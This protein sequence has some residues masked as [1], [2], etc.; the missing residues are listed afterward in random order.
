MSPPVTQ[1]FGMDDHPVRVG[2]FEREYE[3]DEVNVC[4]STCDYWDGIRFRYDGPN[5]GPCVIQRRWR[6]LAYQPD[7]TERGKS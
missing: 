7:T 3:E 6:G 4:E 2:L 5:G 1:W